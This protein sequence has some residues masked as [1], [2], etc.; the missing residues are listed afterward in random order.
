MKREK[1]NGIIGLWKFIFSIVILIFHSRGLYSY[2]NTS[3]FRGG[4]IAVEFFFIVS[5][6]Y[7]AKSVLKQKYDK[8]NIGKETV[9]FISK[10][11]KIF[12]P[13][14]LVA[15]L[16]SLII[17]YDALN[18][19]ALVNSVWDILLLRQFGF[20]RP[21]VAGQIWYLGVMLV[22]MFILYPIIKKHKENY[23]L[24]FSPIIALF[25]LGWLRHFKLSIDNSYANWI[26]LTNS[27]TLR[28]FAEINIGMLIY[29]LSEKLKTVKYTK[30]GR[31]L[32]SLISEG[33]LVL[34]L[35]IV[36]LRSNHSQYDYVLLIFIMISVLIMVSKK[37]YEYKWL[38]NNTIEYFERLSLPIF[39]NQSIFFDLCRYT[40]LIELEPYILTILVV[41]STIVFSMIEIFIFD[42]IK[43]K[44]IL[45]RC[46]KLIIKSV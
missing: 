1:H 35:I 6:Y 43:K 39:V 10:K 15:C 14:V 7:F 28:G 34:V 9:Q 40:S 13:Y 42:L 44:K 41:I 33:L 8:D 24:I 5:G 31:I 17:K 2:L 16:L 30:L 46:S 27:G 38:S 11:I 29:L 21:L 22:S 36:S 20:G 19:N 25:F 23:I 3:L 4:Y 32:L 18:K 45:S 37:T 26:G 12:F